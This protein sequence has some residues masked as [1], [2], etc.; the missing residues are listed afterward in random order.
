MLPTGN[1]SWIY[2]FDQETYDNYVKDPDLAGSCL[3]LYDNSSSYIALEPYITIPQSPFG[4][5]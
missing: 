5:S 4:A 2:Y 3:R 1:D